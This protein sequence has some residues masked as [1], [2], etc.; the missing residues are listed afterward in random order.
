VASLRIYN[1]EEGLC[2]GLER[3]IRRVRVDLERG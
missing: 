3:N 1:L 2:V